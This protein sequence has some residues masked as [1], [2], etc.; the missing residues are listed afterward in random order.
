[1]AVCTF[2]GHRV[3]PPTIGERLRDTLVELIEQKG[4][5]KFYVGNQGMFD[6]A[7]AAELRKLKQEYPHIRYSVV[8]AYFPRDGYSANKDDTMLPEGIELVP[9]RFAIDWRNNWMLSQADYVVTYVLGPGGAAKFQERAVKKNRIV[10][11]LA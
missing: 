3:C 9:K 2:F 11:R 1:M 8:L 7:A 4:V 6:E 5:D 10:I